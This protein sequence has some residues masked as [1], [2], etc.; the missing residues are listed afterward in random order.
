MFPVVQ[1]GSIVLPVPALALLAGVVVAISL[2]EQEAKRLRLPEDA[3]TYLILVALVAG[4]LGARFGYA[5]QFLGIYLTD[6]LGI[7]SPNTSALLPSVGLL[8]GGIAA[9]IYGNRRKLALRPTLDALAPALAVMGVALGV[10]HLAS[11]D[12]FGAPARLLWSIYLWNADRQPSQIYEILGALIVL[13]LWNWARNRLP[14]PGF[15]FILVVAASAVTSIFLEA[16]RG[17]SA[18][19]AGGFRATQ[20]WGLLILVACLLV[21]RRWGYG[22]NLPSPVGASSSADQ[23]PSATSTGTATTEDTVDTVDV[24]SPSSKMPKTS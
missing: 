24:E 14:A 2:A 10:A 3:I 4:I 19:L 8:V 15:G 16:F 23:V 7:F 22:P 11:G 1:L 17:D 5:V 13:G 18:I 6:P 12:A 9:L 20:L 21:I